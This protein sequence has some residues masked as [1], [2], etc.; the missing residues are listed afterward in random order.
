LCVNV[1]WTT[2]TGCQPNCS[3]IIII[4]IIIIAISTFWLLW[5]TLR[6][7]KCVNVRGEYV[8]K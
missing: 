8:V 6:K 4:I 1:Y 5:N 2:A 7:D 3:L